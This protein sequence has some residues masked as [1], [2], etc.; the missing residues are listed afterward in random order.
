MTEKELGQLQKFIRSKEE[1][2][3]RCKEAY[4]Y[5]VAKQQQARGRKEQEAK[6]VKESNIDW[7]DFELVE[8]ITFE[9]DYNKYMPAS[10]M[11]KRQQQ[12]PVVPRTME[13]TIITEPKR[14][15]EIL[16]Q[17]HACRQ[18]I[19]AS[20]MNKHLKTCL[21]HKKRTTGQS[22]AQEG[23]DVDIRKN[24]E[25]LSF[26]RPDIFG[27]QDNKMV[28]EEPSRG[29]EVAYDGQGPTASKVKGTIAI[30]EYEKN[31]LKKQQG[32]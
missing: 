1:V 9:E 24:L 19:L 4:E 12:A 11:V 6:K 2:F 25:G 26:K 21:A 13:E 7:N 30:I 32:K 29:S 5:H 17:C 15:R 3:S 28:A 22:E 18:N 14:K 23:E 10:E 20:E 16:Q 31:K 8:T 27:S